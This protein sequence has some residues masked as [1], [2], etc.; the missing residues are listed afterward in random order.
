MCN[1]KLY[2]LL[3]FKSIFNMFRTVMSNIYFKLMNRWIQNIMQM[4]MKHVNMW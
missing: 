2:E 3:N 1:K 4:I